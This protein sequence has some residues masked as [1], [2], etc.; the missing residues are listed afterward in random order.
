VRWEG[1]ASGWV[2]RTRRSGGAA[3]APRVAWASLQPVE[4]SPSRPSS[5]SRRARTFKRLRE[6]INAAGARHACAQA[7]IWPSAVAAAHAARAVSATL[8]RHHAEL[9]GAE[10]HAAGAAKLGAWRVERGPAAPERGLALL[11]LRLLG[12]LQQVVLR[13]GKDFDV[14]RAHAFLVLLHRRGGGGLVGHLYVGLA[15]G[16]AVRGEG[17]HDAVGAL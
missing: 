10:A 13:A 4:R 9:R 6:R 8:L 14:A 5:S 17:E 2:G 12:G 16:T 7:A 11:E 15:R 3:A 1:D